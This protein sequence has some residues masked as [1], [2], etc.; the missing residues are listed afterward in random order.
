[1]RILYLNRTWQM[2]GAQTIILALLRHLPSRGFSI[3]VGSYDTG[4]RP[5]LEFLDAVRGTGAEI[6][7]PALRW[8][9]PRDLLTVRTTIRDL[10]ARH[11]ID[12]VHT[13]E[14]LSSTLVALTA[15]PAAC[16]R[17]ATA[18]GW[19]ERNRK[20]KALFA[21]ERRL[22]LPRF[23]RVCTVADSLRQRIIGSGV[24]AARV[25]V[26]HTGLELA[27]FPPT[28]D[29]DALRRRFGLSPEAVV[30]GTLGRLAPEKGLHL[31]IDAL[32]RLQH[33]HDRLALLIAGTGQERA[34][35]EERCRALG[36]ADR[37]RFAGFVAEA[38]DAYRAMDVFALPSILPEGLP[39]VAL[40]AQAAGLPVIASDI[41]GT[42][43]T[44]AVG[45]T[46]ELVEPGDVAALTAAIDRLLSDPGERVRMG[47]AARARIERHFT[48][49][50]MIDAIEGI[51]REALAE[52][53][54]G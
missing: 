3:L 13:H 33:R 30:V 2:G 47:A 27:Q 43:D 21:L 46:G 36:L 54:G 6:A 12:L 31:L 8:S 40:E 44:I 20:L 19:W 11:R 29:R 23:D 10:V 25:R 50:A 18:Y 1:M 5:D 35:L 7:A 4:T 15:L 53:R 34:G 45:E 22:A 28:R 9:G 52:R 16:A 48:L 41:G 17:V 14:N 38:I 42:R 39:T 37:V 24:A 32:D 51:Y 49:P 26:V